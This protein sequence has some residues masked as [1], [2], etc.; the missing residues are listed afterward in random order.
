MVCF[1]IQFTV[2]DSLVLLLFGDQWSGVPLG[3]RILAVGGV[4]QLLAYSC[5]W[6]FLAKGLTNWNLMYALVARV[7]VIGCTGACGPTSGRCW[8]ACG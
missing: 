5:Y 1:A 2:A 4:F 6:V 7:L 3:F 8:P